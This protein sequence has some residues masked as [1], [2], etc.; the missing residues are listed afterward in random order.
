V[1]LCCLCV[2]SCS[3]TEPVALVVAAFLAAPVVQQAQQ[4]Q[5]ALATRLKSA[6]R[7]RATVRDALAATLRK[8][9][10]ADVEALISESKKLGV[11]PRLAARSVA[12]CPVWRCVDVARCRCSLH[13]GCLRR[14]GAAAAHRRNR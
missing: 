6:L 5:A 10:V 3:Q 11:R 8:A 4:V 14:D 13:A 2:A 7:W 9:S 1:T 12:H